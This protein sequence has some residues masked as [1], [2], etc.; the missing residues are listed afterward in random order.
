MD[1]TYYGDNRWFYWLWN[2]FGILLIMASGVI[3]KV[4]DI[5]AVINPNIPTN[6]IK[7]LFQTVFTAPGE[8]AKDNPN[9]HDQEIEGLTKEMNAAK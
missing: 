3:Y 5:I 2:N 1:F 6:T 4:L 9:C 7:E 8:C